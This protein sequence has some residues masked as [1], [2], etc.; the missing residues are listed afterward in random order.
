MGNTERAR[1][2]SGSPQHLDQHEH[3]DQPGSDRTSQ[4]LCAMAARGR[5][6]ALC[7]INPLFLQLEL[8]Q[9]AAQ[10]V[11]N[12]RHRFKR[13]MRVRVS[14]E[15]SLNLSGGPR[16]CS[17]PPPEPCGGAERLLPSPSPQ[18]KVHA[19]AGLLK[20]T[21][22]L[23]PTSVEEEE[24][25]PR[26]PPPTSRR[27][28]PQPLEDEPSIEMACLALEG[29]PAP[30]LAD[31]DS[32]S[33]FSS[34]ED[35]SEPDESEPEEEEPDDRPLT[36]TNS[37]QRPPL[38]RSH[39]HGG[40]HRMSAAFVCF[41]APE[42]RLARLVEELS[43]DRRSAF[44]AM[45]L[46]FLQRQREEL[47]PLLSS[48]PTSMS[49]FSFSASTCSSSSSSHP[50][51]S[52]GLL[53]GVRRFLS[54]AKTFLL[55][56]GELEPPIDTLVP[57]NE[58]DLALEKAMFGCVLKPLKAQLSRGL[59][60]LHRLDGSTQKLTD[61][62]HRDQEG[63]LERLGVQVGVPDAR[64]VE[65]VRQK[66][67][68]MQ[69]THSP[70]D[71]VLLLLQVCKCVHQA[72]GSLHGQEVSPEDFL[73][74]LSYLLVQCNRPQLLLE[75]EY[76]MELLEPSWLTGEGGYYLTSVY[77]SL[78]LIQSPEL[79][80]LPPG[81]LPQEAQDQLRA[82]GYRRSREAQ[83][84]HRR[85]QSQRCVRVLF[86]D[87]ERSA[88]RTLQWRAG[89]SREVLAQ[90]CAAT[91]GVSDPQHYTLYWRSGGEMRA[92]PTQAQPQDLASHSEGGPSLSYL[93]T[94][95]DFSKM[96]RLTRGG[97]VDLGESVCEE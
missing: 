83:S 15:S 14:T 25:A 48:Y 94:D 28:T 57:E 76:M 4:D 8:T 69:R 82:W 7:F 36:R 67:A 78:C 59:T 9:Q 23:A 70:I 56:S 1:G 68:L 53:Q 49:S 37:K 80:E 90:L 92:L 32:S 62:L 61:T 35:E 91:F 24:W 17:P 22:A 89:E 3:Q 12:K 33:S 51:T 74:A 52:V 41:F 55:D 43:R 21:P 87:G 96:R 38:V 6:G 65:R 42:K 47:K 34:L 26:P 31:L 44:G 27:R 86:Q 73:P 84:Q 79:E 95:H 77:A 85:L 39:G 50:L 2:S 60:L 54:Q 63:A 45:V 40:L 29:R 93:R 18:R 71:K 58:K 88:V 10:G 11:S 81:F 97:A 75:V 72:M 30:S 66:L 19:G 64:G 13:S 5:L 20:R 16:P 46:D